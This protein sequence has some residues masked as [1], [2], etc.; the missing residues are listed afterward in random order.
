MKPLD[1]YILDLPC[2]DEVLVVVAHDLNKN[3]V[4]C[5]QFKS[6]E[7][8]YRFC[9]DASLAQRSEWHEKHCYKYGCG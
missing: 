9:H 5:K 7:D 3:R 4:L 2:S 1:G 8:A 6:Y